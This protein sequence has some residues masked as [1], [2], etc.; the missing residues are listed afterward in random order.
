MADMSQDFDDLFLEKFGVSFSD[1]AGD[2]SK[3][4]LSPEDRWKLVS[5]VLSILPQPSAALFIHVPKTGGTT[6]GESV[7]E[8]RLRNVVSCDAPPVQFLAMLRDCF[9]APNSRGILFRAHHDYGTIFRHNSP[10]QFDFIFSSFRDPL[11]VHISNATM[12]VERL[13]KFYQGVDQGPAVLGFCEIW[14]RALNQEGLNF[15]VSSTFVAAVL[16]MDYYKKSMSGVYY[17]FFGKCSD[18]Q[19]RNVEFFNYKHFDSIMVEK[20]GFAEPPERKNV[21]TNKRLKVQN[22]A[23]EISTALLEND[24]QIVARIKSHIPERWR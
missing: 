3:F 13:D 7:A 17:R 8:R 22:I 16:S 19:L 2:L 6:F 9:A 12:I 10:S 1:S 11:E 5:E 24:A 15:E 4:K 23:E 21:V 14:D 20:F 18:E